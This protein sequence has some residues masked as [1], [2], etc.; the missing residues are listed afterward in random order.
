[1][2]STNGKYNNKWTII[3]EYLTCLIKEKMR[4]VLHERI[5]LRLL[6]VLKEEEDKKILQP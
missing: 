3:R 5:S 4:E 1:M 2:K 6:M